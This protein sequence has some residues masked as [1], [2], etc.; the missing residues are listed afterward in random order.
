MP[1]V[2]DAITTD[3]PGGAGLAALMAA[4]D[5]A[6]VSLVCA[7]GDDDDG[8]TLAAL[9]GRAGV[10]VIDLGSPRPTP[11]KVRIRADGR[12]VLR[13]DR[14]RPAVVA[15]GAA[16]A[17]RPRRALAHAD[18]ILVADYGYGVAGMDLRGRSGPDGRRAPGG[19]GFRTRGAARRPSG[20]PS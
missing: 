4:H 5:G 8:A 14:S 13:L 17:S 1:V 11:V 18:A 7:L 2:D 3:R 6:D 15:P 19:L 12:T 9:L 10:D 20:R 16:D